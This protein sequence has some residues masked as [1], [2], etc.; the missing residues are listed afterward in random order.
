VTLNWYPKI[1]A[2][3]SSGVV[4]GDAEADPNQ[5][6]LT[7]RHVAFPDLD[8]LYFELECFRERIPTVLEPTARRAP[9]V[10]KQS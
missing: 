2:L 5:T 8:R 3:K 7:A 10:S 1:Q 6:H 4:G 9:D